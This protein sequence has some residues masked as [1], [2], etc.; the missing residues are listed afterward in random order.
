M[1]LKVHLDGAASYDVGDRTR[2]RGSPL[3]G[4]VPLCEDGCRES[5]PAHG[6]WK[7]GESSGPPDVG[8][9]LRLRRRASGVPHE[10]DAGRDDLGRAVPEFWWQLF[11]WHPV[12]GILVKDHVSP[13]Q[14]VSHTFG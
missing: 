12:G 3:R 8:L 9:G 13:C 14:R 7:A 6:S 1:I 2:R 10:A 11:K 4:G 5:Q